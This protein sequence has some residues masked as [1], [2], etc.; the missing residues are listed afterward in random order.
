MSDADTLLL[1]LG[2][3]RLKWAVS[4]TEGLSDMASAEHETAIRRLNDCGLRR[5][6][7]RRVGLS[8]VR[9]GALRLALDEWL[10]D[11]L[12]DSTVHAMRSGE[13]AEGIRCGYAS[14]DQLGVDRWMALIGAWT[15]EPRASLVADIGTAMTLDALLSD[16]THLGGVIAPGPQLMVEATTGRTTGVIA[17]ADARVGDWPDNTADAIVTGAFD[18][19]V[20]LIEARH[21]ALR[22]RV[23]VP[24]KLWLTGGAAAA[25]AR[26]LSA[27]FAM[28]EA[29]VLRGIDAVL[30]QGD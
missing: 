23:G 27:D 24:V 29:L 1:D 28:D 30:R 15:Q 8:D 13:A 9:G 22:Q 12:P 2:N 14:P 7:I 18:A 25:V 20:A 11:A 10:Q 17:N 19:A 3:S 21:A 6:A 4:G 26:R 5:R 16:G